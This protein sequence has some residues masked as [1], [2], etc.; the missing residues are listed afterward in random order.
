MN[1][2]AEARVPFS[3]TRRALDPRRCNI[4]IDADALDR[5]GTANDQLVERF[6]KPSGRWDL[7]VVVDGGVHVEVQHHLCD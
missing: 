5:H 4:G 7:N 2:P 3:G 1:P 6:E